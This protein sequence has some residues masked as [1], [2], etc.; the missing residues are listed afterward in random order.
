MVLGENRV[1]DAREAS[2]RC[3]NGEPT[4]VQCEV[5]EVKCFV[6]C[7]DGGI[8]P[9]IKRRHRLWAVCRAKVLSEF[10]KVIE[11]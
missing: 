3:R 6:G 4:K 9:K 5:C 11:A 10:M 1:G 2:F 8:F 7:E